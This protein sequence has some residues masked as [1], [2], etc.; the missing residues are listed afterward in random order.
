[1]G[2][3]TGNRSPSPSKTTYKF[4][5]FHPD[6]KAAHENG[7]DWG[8]SYSTYN[9]RAIPQSRWQ[10]RKETHTVTSSFGGNGYFGTTSEN[11]THGSRHGR[12]KSISEVI[13]NVRTR[14]GSIGH[15][16]H[17]IADSLKA[18]VS[19][20]ITVSSLPKSDGRCV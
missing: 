13:K 4:P 3:N 20:A 1:M 7:T 16:A 15:N 14:K 2:S 17:E 6:L 10:P 8:S 19:P 12:Q 5:D 18:P 11:T 9:E